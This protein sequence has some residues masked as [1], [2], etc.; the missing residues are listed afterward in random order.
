MTDH[1]YGVFLRPDPATCWN[2]TQVTSA[3]RAQFGITSAGAFAPHATLVGNV[4]LAGATRDRAGAERGL[5]EAMDAV[6]AGV[7]PFP[8]YNSGVRRM[9]EHGRATYQYDIN[10]DQHGRSANAPLNAVA[11]AVKQAVLPL[12]EPVTHL[13]STPVADYEFA[14]HLG[15]ASHELLLDDHLAEEVG[16]YIAELPLTP[17]P[18]SFVARWYTLYRFSSAAWD[19]HWW[20]TLAWDHV[21]SWRATD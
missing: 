7:P 11:R 12:S 4:G 19:G 14:G 6:F 10:R 20:E 18:A 16:E 1:R 21:R 15:L 13:F 8:V 5:I 2:V 17:A 9:V 3:L